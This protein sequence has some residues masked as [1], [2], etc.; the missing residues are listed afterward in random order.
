[1]R[2]LLSSFLLFA[3][4]V[5]GIINNPY[6]TYRNLAAQK[7]PLLQLIWLAGLVLAYFA[8]ASAIKAGIRNPYILTWKFNTLSFAGLFGFLG[9]VVLILIVARVAR[10]SVSGKTIVILWAYSL[11]PTLAWFF[12]TSMLYILLPPPRT[13]TIAGTLYST[14]FITF[15][16]ALGIWKGILYYLTFR[17]GLRFDLFRILL[18]TVI[19]APAVALYSILMYKSGIFRVPFL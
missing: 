12:A 3:K 13:L 5:F 2:I 14:L 1:M 8:F 15:S 9:M 6:V 19:L 7:T 10:V 18:V 11:L 4:N 17:F 16:I